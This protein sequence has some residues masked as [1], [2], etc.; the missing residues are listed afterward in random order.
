MQFI[1]LKG[2][3]EALKNEIDGNIAKV[4]EHGKFISGPEVKELEAEL[5]KYAGTKHCISCANGT[6]AL[7]LVLYA[8]TETKEKA[9]WRKE[10]PSLFSCIDSFPVFFIY[11]MKSQI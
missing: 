2:Q 7:E 11:I 1:D 6:D 8:C 4:L 3:Y 5:A 10:Q 9:E